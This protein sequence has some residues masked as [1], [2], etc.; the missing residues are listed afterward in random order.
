M[1]VTVS[2]THVDLCFVDLILH[3]VYKKKLEW[4]NFCDNKIT[5]QF[6]IV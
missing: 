3:R 4:N 2:M 1:I 5:L 6:F